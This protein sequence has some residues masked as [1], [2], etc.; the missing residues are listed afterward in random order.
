MPLTSFAQGIPTKGWL[1][2]VNSV[3]ISGEARAAI[4]EIDAAHRQLGPQDQA[5]LAAMNPTQFVNFR[6]AGLKFYEANPND[7]MRWAA[8]YRM[9]TIRGEFVSGVKEGYDAAPGKDRRDM[10]IVD[11]VAKEAWEKKLAE[12]DAAMTA[13]TVSNRGKALPLCQ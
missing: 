8:V 11:N 5:V 10:M 7:P 1:V 3:P 2:A 6:E 9:L 4:D 13:A 12:L